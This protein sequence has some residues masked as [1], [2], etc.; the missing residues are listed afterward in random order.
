LVGAAVVVAALVLPTRAQADPAKCQKTIA[1]QLRKY[2]KIY[3]KTNIKC[4]KNQNSGAITGPCPDAAAQTKLN[5]KTTDI[6]AKI[7]DACTSADL[8]ALNFRTD[9]VYESGTSGK[10]ATCAALNV[11]NGPDIDPTLLAQCLECW[12]GAEFREYLAILHASHAL[13]LCGGDLSATSPQCSELDCTT[14]LPDQRNLG[15]AEATCQLGIA[16]GGFKYMFKREKILEK[17]ALAAGTAAS[18][19]GDSEVQAKLN[20]VEQ[21]KVTKIKA[22]CGNRDPNPSPPF[23]CKTGMGNQC[24]AATSRDDCVMNL[25]GTVQEDKTC[26]MGSCAS[27]MGNKQIT[28]WGFCPESDSCPG[29]ALATLDDLIDCVDT[30]ADAIVDKLMCLQFRGNNGA[31]WPCPASE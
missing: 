23:C 24:T 17:C 29:P 12:K 14:P 18:C 3:L 8:A 6:T 21:Q 19:L 5:D 22:K 30:S 15:D 7:A 28:W 10:E 25:M 27:V 2:K 20:M 9:C 31:D 4:L 26:D 13:E 1:T 11:L 16:K